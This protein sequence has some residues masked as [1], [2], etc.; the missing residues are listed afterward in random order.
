V[1]WSRDC[2]HR[3]KRPTTVE[4]TDGSR[5]GDLPHNKSLEQSPW[6]SGENC[7]ALAVRNLDFWA[8][9]AALLNSMLSGLRKGDV[10]L[11]TQIFSQLDKVRWHIAEKTFGNDHSTLIGLLVD[12]WISM[13][14]KT[15]F[16]LEGGPAIGAGPQEH[17]GQCDALFC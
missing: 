8:W 13:S 1:R 9:S 10:M 4:S 14:P 7:Q 12:W 17:R 15:H 16:A 2:C 3:A 6:G 5:S 11:S